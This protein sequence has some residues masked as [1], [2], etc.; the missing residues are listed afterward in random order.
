VYGDARDPA[1]SARRS[2][3]TAGGRVVTITSVTVLLT[4]TIHVAIE[5]LLRASLPKGVTLVRLPPDR[6]VPE[7]VRDAAVLVGGGLP[8]SEL[9]AIIR[10]LPALRWAFRR[11]AYRLMA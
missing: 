11:P 1:A 5:E 4:D 6:C 10:Q 3:D 8:R 2:G 9:S 7:R